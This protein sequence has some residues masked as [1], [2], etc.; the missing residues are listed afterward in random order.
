MDLVLLATLGAISV[1][2]GSVA[3]SRLILVGAAVAAVAGLGSPAFPLAL[4]ASGLALASVLLEPDFVV[5]AMAGGLVAQAVLRLESPQG[6]GLTALV[7][8]LVLV[9]LMV[10]AA[11]TLD[12]DRRRLL[13]KTLLGVGTFCLVGAGVGGAAAAL[14][15][16]PL[17]RGLSVANEAVAATQTTELEGTSTQLDGASTQFGRARRSLESWWAMP[18]RAVPVVAQHWRVL[19]A[20]ALSGDQL[21]GAGRRALAATGL[22]DVRITDGQVPLAQLVAIQPSAADVAARATAAR[23]R[24]SSARSSWL[25]PPLYDKVN[26]ELPR[27]KGVEKTTGL[28]TRVLAVLPRLMGQDGPRRYFLAVQTP[29]EARGGGG[30]LGNFGE[31]TA[32]NGRL[33]LTRFGRQDELTRAVGRDQRVLVA[34]DDFVARYSRFRPENNWS[35]INLSPDF[36]TDAAVMAGLYPQSSGAPVD[37]VIAIDPAALAA[38]LKVVGSIQV[39]SW[40][41][42]ITADTAL[43]TLLFD[44]Y[45]RYGERGPRVD[46]LG[47]VAQEAWRRLTTGGLPPIPQLLAAVGPAIQDKHLFLASTRP[48]EQRL[49]EDMGVAGKIAPVNGDFVGLVTQNAGGNKI[50]YFL[51]RAVDYRVDLDPGSGKLQAQATITLRNDA[52][53]TGLSVGLIGN[54]VVPPLPDGSNKLYLSFYSPW[55][56]TGGRLDGA[57]VGLERETELGRKVYSTALIIAPKSTVTL[58]LTFSGVLRRSKPYRLDLYRQPTVTADDVSTTL[59]LAS[60]WKTTDGTA[61]QT[62]RRQL[63]TDATIEV[64]L[65]RR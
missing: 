9:P 3:S 11:R 18:A 64:P 29:V 2:V 62:T 63:E 14:A 19:H 59:A 42:P 22:S 45:E 50:D 8:A 28:V 60:G 16:G 48:D 24:L 32:D 65:L 26:A 49:F 55:E 23:L 7:A 56:L 39:P 4:A 41:T 52:P 15:V 30:F 46:F 25:L 54:E 58:E 12:R 61:T 37:G 20:A 35:N 53:A 5:D 13:A 43:K 17:R 38:L 31:I 51:R 21:A 36:P 6:R 27:V 44:Q 10:S 1:L 57:E 34:P 40:P 33:S 47:D